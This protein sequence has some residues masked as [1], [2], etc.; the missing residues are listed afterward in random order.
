MVIHI[1]EIEL[2]SADQNQT[3]NSASMY[4][5]LAL[6]LHERSFMVIYGQ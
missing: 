3:T 6:I 5:S 2:H 4:N 1:A